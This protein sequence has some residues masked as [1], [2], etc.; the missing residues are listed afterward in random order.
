MTES[1]LAIIPARGG[2]KRIPRKNIRDFLGKPVIAYSIAA[3][4]DSGLFDEIMVSTDDEEIAEIAI[5][6]G[7][8]VPFLRSASNADD[9]ATTAAVLAEVLAQYAAQ[10][11][12]FALGCCIYPA[13]PLVQVET[14]RAGCRRLEEEGFDNAFPVCRF[15]SAIWRALRLDPQGRVGMLWPEHENTR[16]QDLP[17]AYFDAGQFYW[18]KV[19]QFL[20]SGDLLNDNSS[21]I[22]IEAAHAQDIDTMDDWSMAEF[23]YRLMHA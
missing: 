23:K 15:E 12:Q 18:F 2:S 16:T 19:P 21:A 17:E 4:R 13:A 1:R 7:A 6:Y 3:A 9:H 10:G 22:V 20:R 14:L 8:S 5:R 11:R